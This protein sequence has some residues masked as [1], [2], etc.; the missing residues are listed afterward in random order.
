MALVRSGF[1][2]IP[3]GTKPG[4][5]HADVYQDEAGDTRLYVAHTGADRVDVIDC[6]TKT[7][8]RSLSG[9]PRVAGVL[10]DGDRDF[11]FTSD[12]EASQVSLYRASDETLLARVNVGAHPNG[13]A[14]DPTRGRL[15]SFSLGQP[16]G[17]HCSASVIDVA[18][19][20]VI[21]TIP[22]PGRPRW[23][24]YDP[25]VDRVFAN[26]RDPAQVLAVDTETLRIDRA[27]DVPVEGP[28]GVWIEGDR[29]YCAAGGAALVVLQ[30]D[31]GSVLTQ[32]P[33][34]GVP[35]V[36][37]HDPGLGHLYVA[38]GDPGVICVIDT[39]L[40]QLLE[41]VS[42]EEGAHTIGIDPTSHT[43]FAFL[44]VSEGAGVFSET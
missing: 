4:F 43:V 6:S 35:D 8:L 16:L 21:D 12:R 26:I 44:P 10:I 14:F 37:M 11:L 28:H 31:T 27:I 34:P 25:A 42:T 1:I 22:L 36:V 18:N 5:D 23:A 3:A 20:R 33:L 39:R 38:I 17:E 30:R 2:P 15:F 29:L 9:H 19:G 13:L 41:T 40:L 32:L 7:Y 24:V